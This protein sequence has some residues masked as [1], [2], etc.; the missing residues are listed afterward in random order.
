MWN[1]R[2]LAWVFPGLIAVGL[3]TFVSLMLKVEP[4]ENDLTS[5]ALEALSADHPWANVEVSNRELKLTG[6]APTEAAKIEALRLVNGKFGDRDTGTWGVRTVDGSRVAILAVKSPYVI[7]VKV[8]GGH[9]LLSGFS[10]DRR[11]RDAIVLSAKN[12]FLNKTI[13]DRLT[14]AGG[15]PEE[16]AKRSIFLFELMQGFE[17]G[18]ATLFDNTINVRGITVSVDAFESIQ[19]ALD[20]TLPASLMLD[21]SDIALPVSN[22][23][24][25]TASYAGGDVVLSGVVPDRETQASV[26]REAGK[27][28][29][30]GTVID[31][32]GLASGVPDTFSRKISFAL[33]QLARLDEGSVSLSDSTISIKGRA[34]SPADYA[35]L[36]RIM[37]DTLPAGLVIATR[38]ISPSLVGPH[39]FSEKRDENSVTF[40]DVVPLVVVV[41]KE[42]SVGEIKAAADPKPVV[43]PR[44][45]VDTRVKVSETGDRITQ[46]PEIKPT[47]EI[48]PTL[49]VDVVTSPT[50]KSNGENVTV[51]EEEQVQPVKISGASFTY[52]F[53]AKK[54]EDGLVLEG[55]VSSRSARAAILAAGEKAGNGITADTSII[56]ENAPDGF[57][58]LAVAGIN[59]LS[60]MTTGEISIFDKTLSVQ[61]TAKTPFTLDALHTGLKD[62]PEGSTLGSVEIGVATIFPYAFRATS[63]AGSKE[64]VLTGH[65]PTQ[66][67]RSALILQAEKLG[68]K[69]VTDK[70][71]ISAGA[72]DGF[73]GAA[74]YMLDVIANF[75]SGDVELNNNDIR[76]SGRAKDTASHNAMQALLTS[77]PKGFE[78]NVFEVAAPLVKPYRFSAIKNGEEVFLSGFIPSLAV[79]NDLKA[80]ARRLGYDKVSDEMSLA[81]GAPDGFGVAAFYALKNLTNF[82]D[83]SVTIA[84]EQVVIDGAATSLETYGRAQD[85]LT[86]VPKGFSLFSSH[87]DPATVSPYVWDISRNQEIIS[88]AGLI[89]DETVR[90]M[91]LND[92]ER[93]FPSAKTVDRMQLAD[94]VPEGLDWAQILDFGTNILAKLS[95]GNIS[96]LD[97]VLSVRGTALTN[98]DYDQ[99]VVAISSLKPAGLNIGVVEILRPRVSP[100]TLSAVRTRDSVSIAGYAVDDDDRNRLVQSARKRFGSLLEHVDVTLASGSPE[101]FSVAV[102]NG[103]L[104]LSRLSSGRLEMVDQSV[105]LSGLVPF[106]AS[107]DDIK[108]Q[109]ENSM[110]TSFS[111]EAI[112]KQASPPVIVEAKVCND[113]IVEAITSNRIFFK[114]SKAAILADSYGLLDHIAE[115]ALSCPAA[116]FEISGHTDSDGPESFNQ[117]LSEARARSVVQYLMLAGVADNRFD[118]IGFGAEKPIVS[119]DTQVNK[120]KNR[121]IEF[122]LLRSN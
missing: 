42:P 31:H 79:K 61:G 37:A 27:F 71:Q 23:Y 29:G 30:D 25:F 77:A 103:L 101:N 91:V 5:R 84:G 83:G 11:V 16:L 69:P 39:E 13:D 32:L 57:G 51:V 3:L 7:T 107:F 63:R 122:R 106:G 99:A 19:A 47:P 65:V 105:S 6:I 89:P 26:I 97:A 4:I 52:I 78:V 109:F 72:P 66:A 93:A 67:A 108:A 40:D 50:K 22:P 74:T 68:F 38:E 82:S 119:N 70:M 86:K 94:G 1:F 113:R 59:A 45:L 14:L 88:I 104:A 55:N 76:L 96:V 48:R 110:P 43:E 112:L 81:D 90:Q 56:A 111:A 24:K 64:I 117:R 36:D 92:I 10:P 115:Q 75:E 118:V 33:E 98:E 100:F 28:A 18:E 17:E 15:A 41:P 20:G 87:V 2:P 46:E 121:R 73:T 102:D 120:A 9:V 62:L 60:H 8:D 44:P 34:K 114:T 53:T 85:L 35:I 54:T 116:R 21:Q 95:F 58:K 12:I 80:E 49:E